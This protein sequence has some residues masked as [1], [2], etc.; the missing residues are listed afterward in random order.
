MESVFVE[1]ESFGLQGW[2]VREKS[3]F[4]KDFFGRNFRNSRISFSFRALPEKYRLRN[5][6]SCGGWTVFAQPYKKGTLLS[7]FRYNFGESNL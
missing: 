1:V 3:Q 6:Q 2:N 7:P 4:C 5:I